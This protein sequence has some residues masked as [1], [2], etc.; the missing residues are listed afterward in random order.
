MLWY[1]WCKW[2]IS[3]QQYWFQRKA[4]PSSVSKAWWSVRIFATN[5]GG[6]CWSRLLLLSDRGP[7]WTDQINFQMPSEWNFYHHRREFTSN[8]N[9]T[10]KH[11]TVHIDTEE[12]LEFLAAPFQGDF[13]FVLHWGRVH[14]L[15]GT[16]ACTNPCK[17]SLI[18]G[19][20]PG[21]RTTFW[22]LPAPG[23][24]E[25]QSWNYGQNAGPQLTLT[26]EKYFPY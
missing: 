26:Y 23:S 10:K 13:S 15:L 21:G 5:N 1:K 6:L 24:P 3:L 25:M 2:W 4:R 22:R 7:L 18:P 12:V 16:F 8:W 17:W 9:N 14:Y 20:P 11:G 19:Q